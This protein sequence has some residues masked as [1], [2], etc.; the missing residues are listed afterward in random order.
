MFFAI[1]IIGKILAGV[2]AAEFERRHIGAGES[3]SA[4]GASEQ[5]PDR[6][7]GI[8]ADTQFSGPDRRQI[9]L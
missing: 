1:P 7:L 9:V 3:V 5:R 8:R 6:S 4:Q 2:A